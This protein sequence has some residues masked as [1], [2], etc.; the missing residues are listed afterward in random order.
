MTIHSCKPPQELFEVNDVSTNTK[1]NLDRETCPDLFISA[2][3]V[4]ERNKKKMY[5]EYTVENRG[6][7]PAYLL[8]ESKK[9]IDNISLQVFFSGDKKYNRGDF[10]AHGFFIEKALPASNGKLEAGKSYIG[11]VEISLKRKTSFQGNLIF[12]IDPVQIVDECDETNNYT[13]VAF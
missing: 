6:K 7:G 9:K 3:N 5:V 11:G 4:I 8:G 12:H 2:I 1:E 10:L 13:T